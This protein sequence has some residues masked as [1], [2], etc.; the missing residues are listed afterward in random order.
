ME[1]LAEETIREIGRYLP[2]ADFKAFRWAERFTAKALDIKFC[3]RQHVPLYEELRKVG[4]DDFALSLIKVRSWVWGSGDDMSLHRQLASGKTDNLRHWINTA[5]TT[6]NSQ[7]LT[8]ILEDLKA[9]QGPRYIIMKKLGKCM[10]NAAEDGWMMGVISLLNT[11]HQLFVRERDGNPH[12][13]EDENGHSPYGT[14]ETKLIESWEGPLIR[15]ARG[16]HFAVV[17]YIIKA[18]IPILH[19]TLFHP[20]FGTF[21]TRLVGCVDRKTLLKVVEIARGRGALVGIWRHKGWQDYVIESVLTEDDPSSIAVLMPTVDGTHP[22]EDMRLLNTIAETAVNCSFPNVLKEVMRQL[23]IMDVPVIWHE[24]GLEERCRTNNLFDAIA[25]IC[26][27]ER[28]E[29]PGTAVETLRA[30]L[31]SP[32]FTSFVSKAFA[33]IVRKP[34]AILLYEFLTAFLVQTRYCLRTLDI[35]PTWP[36]AEAIEVL[37]QNGL[38]GNA[39]FCKRFVEG[40]ARRLRV[41]EE[42]EGGLEGGRGAETVDGDVKGRESERQKDVDAEEFAGILETLVRHGLDVSD[43]RLVVRTLVT[44]MEVEDAEVTRVVVEGLK[45][46]GAVVDEGVWR[47]AGE[48][49]FGEPEDVT[50]EEPQPATT[51]MRKLIVVEGMGFRCGECG[52][53]FKGEEFVV[54]HLG[55]KHEEILRGGGGADVEDEDLGGFAGKQALLMATTMADLKYRVGGSAVVAR[56]LLR[57]GWE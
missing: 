42:E 14:A 35:F 39:E 17:D 28:N 48:R 41:E 1:A 12:F 29:N 26:C 47:R 56:R 9:Y 30:C 11:I 24:N 52:K 45:S 5:V 8:Y 51:I 27:L 57:M 49:A 25:A 22:Y 54:K 3:L 46:V 15:A 33:N 36:K 2:L 20:W 50:V 10:S 37:L 31:R 23:Q 40:V 32:L 18:S 21:M 19:E 44:C 38:S 34:T 16:K 6:R 13:Y 7:M 53:L 4:G 55:N 43:E